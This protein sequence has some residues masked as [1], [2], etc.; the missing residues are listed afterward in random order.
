MVDDVPLR[1]NL[2]NESSPSNIPSMINLLIEHTDHVIA[3]GCVDNFNTILR[4]TIEG[5]RNE[6]M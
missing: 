3:F 4:G 6:R 1:V 2:F 5:L